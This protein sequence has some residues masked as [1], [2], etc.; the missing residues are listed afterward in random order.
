MAIFMRFE[1]EVKFRE[2]FLKVEGDKI[3]V[4]LKQRPEGGKANI[5]LIK[6]LAK[7]F[8]VAP[9]QVQIVS[10]MRSRKKV[11]YIKLSP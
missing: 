9:S 10:G 7:H 11:I 2:D 8:M 6:K 3:F 5:E 4:G 1:V